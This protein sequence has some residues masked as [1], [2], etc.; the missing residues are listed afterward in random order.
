[1]EM[2][3]VNAIFREAGPAQGAV[4]HERPAAVAT[5]VAAP[6]CAQPAELGQTASPE[7]ADQLMRADYASPRRIHR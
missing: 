2:R 3:S 4:V 7:E 6:T 1:M 5:F